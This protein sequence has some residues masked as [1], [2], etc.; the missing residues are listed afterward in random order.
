MLWWTPLQ[1][2]HEWKGQIASAY[3]ISIIH[4]ASL[5]CH[6]V[7]ICRLSP[8]HQVIHCM[9]DVITHPIPLYRKG[10]PLWPTRLKNKSLSFKSC[11]GWTVPPFFT[12]S[13]YPLPDWRSD[14]S[15]GQWGIWWCPLGEHSPLLFFSASLYTEFR[16][17]GSNFPWG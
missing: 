3:D 14:S 17:M 7:S 1:A 5:G 10:F 9:S 15:T 4:A 11:S 2:R 6:H 12:N 16:L 13:L 8:V